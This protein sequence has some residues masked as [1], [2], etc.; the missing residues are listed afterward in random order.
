[1]FSQ[2]QYVSDQA[3]PLPG[4]DEEKKLFHQLQQSF[5]VQFENIF[6]DRLAKKTIIIIPSLTLD[7]EILLKLRGHIYYEERLLCLL[8]LL[9]M[10]QTDQHSRRGG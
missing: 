1:M 9:Q 7:Q 4:S 10:P 8:M 3:F 2:K 6:S 5:T